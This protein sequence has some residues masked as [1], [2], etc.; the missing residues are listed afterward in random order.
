MQNMSPNKVI[1]MVDSVLPNA[2]REEEKL[3]WLSDLDGMVQRVAWQLPAE[4]TV[5]YSFP[6]DLDRELLIPPPFDNV[7]VL[8]VRAMIDF[9]NNELEKYNASAQM[10]FSRFEDYKKA[11]LR[12]NV[13]KFTGYVRL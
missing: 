7:Y 1:E 12:E 4:E 6:E 13:P 9:H 8:Y 5:T 3:Q 2:Y 10:F 11:Y